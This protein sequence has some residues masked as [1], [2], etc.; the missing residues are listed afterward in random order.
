MDKKK[1]LKPSNNVEKVEIRNIICTS[2]N[3][4]KI[5]NGVEDDEYQDDEL[6]EIGNNGFIWGE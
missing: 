2:A 4:M 1:Y 5:Y 3:T 6:P